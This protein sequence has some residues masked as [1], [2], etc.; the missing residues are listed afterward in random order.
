MFRGAH[1]FTS[2]Y[3]AKRDKNNAAVRKS[4]RKRAEEINETQR[5]VLLL[6]KEKQLLESQAT[7]LKG[8]IKMLKD[9]C[10][11]CGVPYSCNDVN[12]AVK[13]GANFFGDRSAPQTEAAS[14]GV[15]QHGQGHDSFSPK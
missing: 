12:A 3:R 14:D 8:E 11:K 15:L 10:A 4:R 9:L 7:A 2:E 5:K 1:I 6:E 13:S